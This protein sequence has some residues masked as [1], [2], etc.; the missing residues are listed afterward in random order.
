MWIPCLAQSDT[1]K[2][3]SIRQ[4]D[5]LIRLSEGLKILRDRFDL[6][7]KESA[8]F[9]SLWQSEKETREKDKAD[10]KIII[11]GYA[12]IV[13][14]DKDKLKVLERKYKGQVRKNRF[15]FIISIAAV[16]FGVYSMIK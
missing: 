8:T 12:A 14:S 11:D 1:T 13:A 9:K 16:S 15:M 6:S 5:S 7:I 4:V 10:Y 3:L 2:K